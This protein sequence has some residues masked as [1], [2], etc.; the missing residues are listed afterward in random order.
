MHVMMGIDF[1]ELGNQP[2]AKLRIIQAKYKLYMGRSDVTES[3]ATIRSPFC[4]YNT[5]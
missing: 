2:A 4:G 3:M 5:A 1:D